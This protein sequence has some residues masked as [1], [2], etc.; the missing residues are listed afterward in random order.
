MRVA[1]PDSKYPIPINANDPQHPAAIDFY[2]Q[3]LE[4]VE[5]LPGVKSVS[6]GTILPF[7]AGTG[8]GKNLSVEGR[9]SP[10]SIDQVPVVRFALIS[11]NYFRTF[12]VAIRQGREFTPQ[13]NENSQPVAIINES[14]ARRFF[15]EEDPVGKTIWMGPPEHLLP[16]EAQSP[17]NRIP[18]RLIVGVVADVKGGSL[19][20]P[21]SPM[22]YAPYHQY[23]R[24]GWANTLMLAVRADTAPESLAPAIRGQVKSLDQEQPVSSVRTIEELFDRSLSESRFTLLLLGLFAGAAVLLAAIGIY[25]V[26]SYSVAQRVHEIGIR[27]ALGARTRD[28][29][30]M[31]IGQGMRLALIGVFIGLISSFALTRLMESLLYE[32]SAVDPLTFAGLTILLLGVAL[33]ACYVPARRAAKVDPMVAL[34]YE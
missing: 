5:A 12:G 6:L 15:P 33:V 28:V 14:L 29:L 23:R 22:V 11:P 27:V 17:E 32:V 1:L 19:N 26:I 25:G 31:V 34:R 8:W 3:L 4:R 30:G 18:R 13:D 16:P 24:E 9:P 7:G 20:Q 21:A 10:P 2:D